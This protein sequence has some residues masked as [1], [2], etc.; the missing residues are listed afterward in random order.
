MERR[1]VSKKI[2]D[3]LRQA[4]CLNDIPETS[5]VSLMDFRL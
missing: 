3:T 4:G 5:Q 2:I 1:K